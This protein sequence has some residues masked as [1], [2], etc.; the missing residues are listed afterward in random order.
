MTIDSPSLLGDP[1]AYAVSAHRAWIG[2]KEA[3]LRRRTLD[4]GCPN[5]GEV[6]FH[7]WCDRLACR[8]HA[9][10]PHDCGRFK[11]KGGI[12]EGAAPVGAIVMPRDASA[13]VA[14][15]RIFDE[16]H[17]FTLADWEEASAAVR[18][19]REEQGSR[20]VEL[21]VQ[22]S[23][24]HMPESVTVTYAVD[25]SA[26]GSGAVA[27]RDSDGHIYLTA[28]SPPVDAALPPEVQA[29]IDENGATMDRLGKPMANIPWW[30][31]I[32]G[33]AG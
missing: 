12:E 31:R 3:N 25:V 32:L 23:W 27:V 28:V 13:T 5:R 18:A 26:E 22:A 33:G 29:V 4:C 11:G 6:F 19:R 20:A 14:T 21:S 1:G 15:T 8:E 17:R 10:A 24:P 9:D 16:T 7:L 2:R 30:R